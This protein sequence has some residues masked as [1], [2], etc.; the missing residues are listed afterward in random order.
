MYSYC[1]INSLEEVGS[2]QIKN[3]C[4]YC[5]MSGKKNGSVGRDLFLLLFSF[6]NP[7]N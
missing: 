1:S 5:N 4:V 2:G 3:R 6:F 7:N